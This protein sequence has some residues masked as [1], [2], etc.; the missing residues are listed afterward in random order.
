[1]CQI[2]HSGQVKVKELSI[3]R[4]HLETL[5]SF[6]GYGRL[7]L[8]AIAMCFV[9][10]FSDAGYTFTVPTQSSLEVVSAASQRQARKIPRKPLWEES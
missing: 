1:M 8:P 10:K 2:R 6:S 4:R 3:L 5:S 9:H 7:G